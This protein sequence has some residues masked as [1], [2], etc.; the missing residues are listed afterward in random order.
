MDNKMKAFIELPIIH[1]LN[2]ENWG[3]ESPSIEK[4]EDGFIVQWNYQTR[5]WMC[6]GDWCKYQ[7]W[8]SFENYDYDQA[9]EGL[10]NFI[11]GECK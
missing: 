8:Y 11:K 2:K 6:Q 4:V 7:R 10:T 3:L 1:K 5:S 9:I